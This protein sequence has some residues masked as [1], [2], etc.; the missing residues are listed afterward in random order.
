MPGTVI[1]C[2]NIPES[3]FAAAFP[4]VIKEFCLL[5]I[6]AILNVGPQLNNIFGFDIVVFKDCAE[7]CME[8]CI[9]INEFKLKM[10]YKSI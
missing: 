9:L 4:R 8:R 7:F 2:I 1:K 5:K 3:H 6:A 10:P